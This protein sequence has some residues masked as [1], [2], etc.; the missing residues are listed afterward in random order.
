MVASA[1]AA[2]RRSLASERLGRCV[3]PQ[4]DKGLTLP[5]HFRKGTINRSPEIPGICYWILAQRFTTISAI[6]TRKVSGGTG[7]SKQVIERCAVLIEGF[8]RCVAGVDR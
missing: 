5:G 7:K 4:V 6:T 3:A 2:P 1:T 8:F